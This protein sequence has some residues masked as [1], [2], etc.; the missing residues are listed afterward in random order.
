MVS[1]ITGPPPKTTQDRTQTKDTHLI[2][3]QELKIPGTAGN[4]TRAAGLEGRDS[5][6][7]AT[8]TDSLLSKLTKWRLVGQVIQFAKTADT[9]IV[10]IKVVSKL[11]TV[12]KQK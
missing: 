1:T 11:V 10:P 12:I 3:G 7:H 2:P 8:A 4:R 9:G 5:T 6:D